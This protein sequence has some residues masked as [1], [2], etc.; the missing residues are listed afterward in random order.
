MPDK[1]AQRFEKFYLLGHTASFIF[2]YLQIPHINQR[3]T[4]EKMGETSKF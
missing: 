1:R 2:S 4:I 3:D